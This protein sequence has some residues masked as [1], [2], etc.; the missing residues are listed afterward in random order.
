MATMVKY[1][2][3]WSTTQS[4]LSKV[5]INDLH[6]TPAKIFNSKGKDSLFY[7]GQR[8]ASDITDGLPAMET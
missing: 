7:Y 8:G 6:L 2:S 4:H 3:N 5:S 1:S